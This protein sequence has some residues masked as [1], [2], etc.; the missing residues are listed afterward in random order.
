MC[1][2]LYA[3]RSPAKSCWSSSYLEDFDNCF[4]FRIFAQSDVCST[5]L[6]N[7]HLCLH[8]ENNLFL[9]H[10]SHMKTITTP[11]NK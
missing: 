3:H 10:S 8:I 9:S 4:Y 5:P 2:H 7:F 1:V 11:E 6:E